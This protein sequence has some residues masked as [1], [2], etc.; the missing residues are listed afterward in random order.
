MPGPGD[1]SRAGIRITDL[2]D[3]AGGNLADPPPL[4][5]THDQLDHHT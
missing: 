1:I 3:L 2:T 4:R 5:R